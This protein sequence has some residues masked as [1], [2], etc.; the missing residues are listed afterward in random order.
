VWTSL[1]F[2]LR[3]AALEQLQDGVRRA[4]A[5]VRLIAHKSGALARQVFL[6]D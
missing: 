5:G 2:A 1:A 6:T 4:D 3:A